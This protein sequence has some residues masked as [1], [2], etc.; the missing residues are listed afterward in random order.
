MLDLGYNKNMSSNNSHNNFKSETNQELGQKIAQTRQEL[1]QILQQ[2]PIKNSHKDTIA[3]R[4]SDKVAQIVG[5]WNF[6]I[7]QSCLITVWII[8]NVNIPESGLVF[9]DH[10]TL[11]PWD[12][13]PFI[14]LNLTLSF[15]AA[16][17]APIIMM[18]QN[19]Q[20]EIDRENAEADYRINREA[21]IEVDL[22]KQELRRMH[23]KLLKHQEIQQDM[24][25]IA[26]EIQ[27]LKELLGKVK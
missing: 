21:K 9:N 27:V 18:S 16:Y 14:F 11:K 25:I 2:Q 24:S 4:V 1:D 26:K 5:S 10:F 6:I 7:I 23:N 22:I 13:Y 3:Q 17:T 8:F 15:Q 20:S 12:P 19:R